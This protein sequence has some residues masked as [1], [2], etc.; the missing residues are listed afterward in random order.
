MPSPRQLSFTMRLTVE[1]SRNSAVVLPYWQL[2]EAAGVPQR[3]KHLLLLNES[4]LIEAGGR[5]EAAYYIRY[6][7][8]NIDG[9]GVL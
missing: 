6:S 1:N 5:L 8:R 7:L 2:E 3:S 4:E 9:R